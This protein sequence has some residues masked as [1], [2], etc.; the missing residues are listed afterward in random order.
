MSAS[1]F[2][3]KHKR[4]PYAYKMRN[5]PCTVNGHEMPYNVS[6]SSLEFGSGVLEWCFSQEDAE[7]ILR[8]MQR[9][10]RFFNL[11]ICQTTNMNP[12][13]NLYSDVKEMIN[14]PVPYT[15]AERI[16]LFLLA[17]FKEYG[18]RIISF[19]REE[20]DI[21]EPIMDLLVEAGFIVSNIGRNR[22][23]VEIVD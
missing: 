15:D 5:Y 4:K 7:D 23:S 12:F 18:S 6:G 9:D 2:P 17:R 1:T 16:K 20:C 14:H 3:H 13:T 11:S 8:R 19:Y 10:D 21:S 22:I